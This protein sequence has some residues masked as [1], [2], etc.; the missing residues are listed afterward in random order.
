MLFSI[1][2]YNLIMKES[3]L[4]SVRVQFSTFYIICLSWPNVFILD[5]KS[6]YRKFIS[7]VTLDDATKTKMTLEIMRLHLN[8]LT[9]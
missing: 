8:K 1:L 5:V 4:F 6:D 2:F 3:L 9:L 7:I